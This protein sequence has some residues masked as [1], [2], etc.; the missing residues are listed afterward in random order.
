MHSVLKNFIHLEIGKNKMYLT[1]IFI[2]RDYVTV[3]DP[4]H[5][6]INNIKKII[7]GGKMFLYIILTSIEARA[8]HGHCVKSFFIFNM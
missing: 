4:S 6:N 7:N 1:K 8:R 2:Y 5:N 3:I